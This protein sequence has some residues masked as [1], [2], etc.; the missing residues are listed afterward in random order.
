MAP[1][2]KDVPHVNEVALRSAGLVHRRVT[3]YICLPSF[4]LVLSL[5]ILPWVG[6][7]STGNGHGNIQG[8]NGEF[9]VTVGPVPEL[10]AH[11]PNRLKALA[12]K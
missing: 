11:W 6:E 12:A 1:C 4:I 3:T 2:G 9:Y 7:M 8:R 10:L 5:A